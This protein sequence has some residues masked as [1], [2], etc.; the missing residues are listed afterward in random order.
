MDNGN[1]AAAD[2]YHQQQEQQQRFQ[3]QVNANNGDQQQTGLPDGYLSTSS[4]VGGAQINGPAPSHGNYDQASQ[5]QYAQTFPPAPEQITYMKLDRDRQQSHLQQQ[6]ARH[7][8]QL[9]EIMS[10]Q[11]QQQQRQQQPD[12]QTTTPMS[13]T[14]LSAIE[15]QEQQATKQQELDIGQQQT[16]ANNDHSSS[17]NNGYIVEQVQSRP[18]VQSS[19]DSMLINE[20]PIQVPITDQQSLISEPNNESSEEFS[21]DD[22]AKQRQQSQPAGVYQ[23]YQAYYA[24]KNHKPLPGYVR[25]SLE[26]FNEL[27]RDAEIQYVDRGLNGL[28]NSVQAA[29]E[30]GHPQPQQ[31]VAESLNGYE[32]Q[33]SPN[34]MM[35]ASAS[36]SQS[37]VVDQRS[38]SERR[39]SNSTEAAPDHSEAEKSRLPN[40]KLKLG[41]AVK[42]IISIRNS[43]QSVKQTAKLT[44]GKPPVDSSPTTSSSNV[45]DSPATT[46]GPMKHY[47]SKHERS[48][49]KP[50][51]QMLN[52][53]TRKVEPTSERNNPAQQ[54]QQS[55]KST[56]VEHKAS[57]KKSTKIL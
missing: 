34:D 48:D 23:V 38:I 22:G 41:R 33:A 14:T 56:K 49:T 21:S 43:R 29:G 42:K 13:M 44:H 18:S 39:S 40:T 30:G 55:A 46:K 10:D 54:Q 6:Q 57:D 1:E 24:P 35:K 17:N 26:E 12:Y 8:A 4:F 28:A 16:N 32:Q 11:A 2:G 31:P 5:Q 51:K 25:L 52:Q 53:S 15:Q 19:P 3:G 27:F 45:V 50:P 37:I 36:E 47:V 20:S 7:Q 9:A